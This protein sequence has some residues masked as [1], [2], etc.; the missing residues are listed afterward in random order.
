M[1]NINDN[2]IPV[3]DWMRKNENEFKH[4]KGV[5]TSG[6][7]GTVLIKNGFK[8]SKTEFEVKYKK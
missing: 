2:Y 8:K 6:Q 4:I 7:V 5:P 1:V 3:K